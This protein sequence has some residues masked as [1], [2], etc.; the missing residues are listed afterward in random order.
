[1]N[2]LHSAA[3]AEWGTP[4]EIV[5]MGRRVLGGPFHLDP[6]TSSYWNHHLVRAAR[7]FDAAAD[8]DRFFS[9][10]LMR[11]IPPSRLAFMQTP[12]A[13]A[14]KIEER[15]A[16]E[17]ATARDL[18]RLAELR[19]NLDG[20]PV[21]GDSPTH[22]CYLALMPFSEAQRVRFTDACAELGAEVF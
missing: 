2:A 21:V 1:M 4:P 14:A 22:G 5:E 10:D 12:R 6:A 16:K 15:I 13:A 11:A 9:R 19:K 17:K 18:E 3:T 8:G 20:P 7:Y